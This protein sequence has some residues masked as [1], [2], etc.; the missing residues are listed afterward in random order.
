MA[1]KR[2]KPIRM[3]VHDKGHPRLDSVLRLVDAASQ[4][5]PFAELLATLCAELAQVMQV[6]VV[7][8]YVREH[9]PDADADALVMRGNIGFPSSAIGNVRLGVGEGITGFV[10]ECMRPVSCA[11]GQ[12]EDHWKPVAGLGEERFP[13]FLAIPL[14]MSGS[15][16]GVLVFQRREAHAFDGPDLLLA[17][18]LTAPVAFAIER[19]R[20]RRDAASATAAPPGSRSARLHGHGVA[21]GDALG[22]VETLPPLSAEPNTALGGERVLSASV[23]FDQIS[24]ELSR[25]YA[26]VQPSLDADARRRMAVLALLFDDQ[27]LRELA[28]E[29]CNNVGLV[30]GLRRVAREY[31]RAPYRAGVS[32]AEGGDWMA[33]RAAEVED[34]C[35]LIAAH[36]RG[37]R[38]PSAGG[39]LIVERLTGCLALAGVARHAS[40]F[41]IAG[42]VEDG[43]LGA[44][45]LAAAG[46]PA[47]S[48]VAELFVWARPGDRVLIDGG[49]GIVRINPP[50]SAEARLRAGA[51]MSEEKATSRRER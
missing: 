32:P 33:E 21:P 28:M 8:I 20:A 23:A 42:R 48:E 24:R 41:A 10:A 49:N 5:R 18:A 1:G 9:D 12:A 31:A 34:L 38:A 29:E 44:A 7:S 35:L 40:G 11:V 14:L 37:V 4:A 2:H 45:V 17:A 19:S 39:V 26:R 50:A 22:R 30:P 16:V 51:P 43:A 3:R 27:R 15:C 36:A 46:V 13:A 25:G 6:E 47:V